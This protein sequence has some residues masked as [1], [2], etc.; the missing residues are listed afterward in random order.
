[1]NTLTAIIAFIGGVVCGSFATVF[2][3][4]L[5]RTARKEEPMR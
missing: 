3:I 4:A 1:M 5:G 2:A